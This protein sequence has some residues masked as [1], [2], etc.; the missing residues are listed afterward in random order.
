MHDAQIP[1]AMG[2]NSATACLI[3]KDE[4][5]YL[6]EW[7]SHY[8]TLG[9]DR[10]VIY[11]NGSSDGS[12]Q[13]LAK[14]AADDPRLEWRPWP[15]K[16][17]QIAQDSAYADALAQAQTE[18]IGYFDADELLVLKDDDSIAAFVAR[19]GAGVGAVAINWMMFGSSG[20]E[21]YR[22]ELQAIRFRQC[23]INYH[24]KTIAR[25][26][27]A[28]A[29]YAHG[30]K[31]LSGSYVNDAGAPVELSHGCKTQALSYEHAQVNHYVVRSAEEFAAKRARGYVASVPGGTNFQ[32]R[33]EEFWQQNDHKARTDSAVD[34]WTERAAP[35]REH[36]R[37]LLQEA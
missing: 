30:V 26:R 18:W 21:F 7:I 35:L 4:A 17:G 29:P 8:F 23:N 36:Y 5:P 2:G 22:D 20:E 28:H 14:L 1:A 12:T 19:F 25:V 9:F 13:L 11:D 15:N 34:R 10:L 24:V 6:L 31:L 37:R 3:A 32:A 16:P 33:D 27:C